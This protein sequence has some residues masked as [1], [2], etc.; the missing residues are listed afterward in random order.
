MVL[1]LGIDLMGGDHSPE[2]VLKA[3]IAIL[4]QHND[5]LSEYECLLVPIISEC[6]E[7]SLKRVC[8]EENVCWE[9]LNPII[10]ENFVEMEDSPLLVLRRKKNSTMAKG[11]CLLRDGFLDGL[12]ST[13]NTGALFAFACHHLSLMQFI[14]RPALLVRLPT[15]KGSV[16]VLDVGANVSVKPKDLLMFAQ[17]GKAYKLCLDSS[18]IPKLG[19]LNIGREE[20]KGTESHRQTFSLLQENF[21]DNFFGNIESGDVFRGKVDVVVTD[22]FT[23]NIFL[24]TAEGVAD[25]FSEIFFQKEQN[26]ISPN[27]HNKVSK[28][29][30]LSIYQGS[31]LCGLSKLVVKCHGFSDHNAL[32]N[33]ILNTINLASQNICSKMESYL[34]I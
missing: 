23:G 27:H 26:F 28:S 8:I 2:S 17:M 24:K 29:L 18:E 22:G 33:G 11:I 31:F 34:K 14:E 20:K 7:S 30:D 32:I 21:G 3:I 25:C 5:L 15:L 10:T 6:V 4:K 19:L 12:V 13:G 16:I 1:R 9:Y